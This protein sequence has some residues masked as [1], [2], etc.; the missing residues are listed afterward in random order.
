MPNSGVEPDVA[1]W[2]TSSAVSD[3]FGKDACSAGFEPVNLQAKY[4]RELT[5]DFGKYLIVILYKLD[6]VNGVRP[7]NDAAY[8]SSESGHCRSRC[9]RRLAT[10]LKPILWTCQRQTNHSW[11]EGRILGFAPRCLVPRT[12]VLTELYYV[13]HKNR[14][15]IDWIIIRRSARE[16]TFSLWWFG[17][18]LWNTLM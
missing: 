8:C 9:F 5:I 6:N 10:I 2:E 13:L 4:W 1:I 15:V 7:E 3:E 11:R 17:I 12:S 14:I 18:S 16:R